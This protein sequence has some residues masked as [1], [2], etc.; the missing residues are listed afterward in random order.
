VNDALLVRRLERLGD[1]FR[2]GER[3]VNRDGAMREAVGQR[4][5]LDELHDQ[6][7]DAI[8]LLE[9]ID[10]RDV[11]MVQGGED[12]GFPLKT[13]QPV[14][15]PCDVGRED[16]QRPDGS[17]WCPSRGKPRPCRPHQPGRSLRI[18]RVE[19]RG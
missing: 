18:G 5:A 6:R 2:D 17:A 11:R 3:L 16:L 7:G 4:Q 14:T 13:S 10:R 1:L 12:F 15:V 8:R 9:A 19:Y